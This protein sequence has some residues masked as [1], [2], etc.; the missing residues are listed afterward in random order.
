[1]ANGEGKGEGFNRIVR[2]SVTAAFAGT[3]C[4]LVLMIAAATLWGTGVDKT[5]FVSVLAI[6][7][8][9]L[10]M[11]L[12]FWFVAAPDRKRSTDT[13]SQPTDQRTQA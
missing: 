6:F 9:S 4:A 5:L 10:T 13:T 11:V 12:T 8:S 3:A 2:G 1:M 7:S